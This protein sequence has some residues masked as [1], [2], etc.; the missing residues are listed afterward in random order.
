MGQVLAMRCC[1]AHVARIL[2][3]LAGMAGL[4]ALL[5]GCS[6]D[7]SGVTSA[8][9]LTETFQREIA[10][11]FAP[12]PDASRPLIDRATA[13]AIGVP[14]LYVEIPTI[15]ARAAVTV[16]AQNGGVTTWLSPDQASVMLDGPVLF[17]TRGIGPDLLSAETAPLRSRLDAGQT[18]SYD[19][20]LRYLDGTDQV[21]RVPLSC[22]LADAGRETITVL[23]RSHATSRRV[24]RCTDDAGAVLVSE[25]WIGDDGV[26]WQTRQFVSPDL[27]Q[28]LT[29][30]LNL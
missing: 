1:G 21:V 28:V 22:T 19:R 13:D 8:N 24:E 17:A 11:R 26:P 14:L 9:L 18:G 29:Q 5:A 16:G 12:A 3:G 20:A 30:T 15:G 4:G 25:F 7:P 2:R 10:S 6:T 23:G 27:G